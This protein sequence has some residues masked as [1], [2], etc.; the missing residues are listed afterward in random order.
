M[1]QETIFLLHKSLFDV[2]GNLK[3]HNDRILKFGL[4]NTAPPPPKIFV[5][6]PPPPEIN[7]LLFPPFGGIFHSPPPPPPCHQ[8]GMS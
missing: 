4:K 6:P 8:W 3:T 7:F 2:L 5:P 1:R